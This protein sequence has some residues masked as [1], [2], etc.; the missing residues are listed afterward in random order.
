MDLDEADYLKQ[1][2]SSYGSAVAA[3]APSAQSVEMDEFSHAHVNMAFGMALLLGKYHDCGGSH[4]VGAF[5]D[6][7]VRGRLLSRV[8]KHVTN[9]DNPVALDRVL[10]S[11]AFKEIMANVNPKHMPA[12]HVEEKHVRAV[13]TSHHPFNEA[14]MRIASIAGADDTALTLLSPLAQLEN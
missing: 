9:F 5:A 2:S 1:L 12:S 10:I 8:L 13:L 4:H 6:E 7:D 3:L 14:V 11:V